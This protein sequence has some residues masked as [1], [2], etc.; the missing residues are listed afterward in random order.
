MFSSK[1]DTVNILVSGSSGLIGSALVLSVTRVGHRVARLVRH[2]RLSETEIPWDPELDRL[3]PGL[4]EGFDAI[5][6]LA[7]ENIAAGSWTAE[8][9]ARIRETR[10]RG[11]S[12]L[13]E[14][15]AAVRNRPHVLV[16]ASA[17]GYY[18]NRG[19]E[20]L[21]EESAPGSGFLAEVCE[22][23]EAATGIAL[24]QGIRVVNLR[25]GI[26]LSGSGGALAKMLT[27]F[28]MGIG[29]VIGSGN[30]Y[31]SWIALDDVIAVIVHALNVV[32]VRGPV[33]VV[34]PRPVTN[35]E[36]TKTLARVLR[37]PS[38]FPAPAFALRLMFGEMADALL[39]ASQRVEPARLAASQ[40][41]FSYPEL[42]GAL[43][44]ALHRE[45]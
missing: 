3:D 12:L 5:V 28:R 37:R 35:R 1:G 7:G 20:I 23:W 26:V 31:M 40:F 33:N 22:E 39:L 16:S 41:A 30:Q 13:S 32:D 27:P 21:T 19:D 45:R 6:H 18:G 15:L 4:L 24:Q 14:A 34:A 29:G 2:R 42:E 36:F 38:V 11:T 25:T 17:T 43:R 9:K 8:R 10:V 44:H